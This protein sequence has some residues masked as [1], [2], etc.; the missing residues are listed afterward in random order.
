M[1]IVRK[2]PELPWTR[3]WRNL[4]AAGLPDTIKSTSY[5]ATHDIIPTNER[6]A[7]IHPVPN[8]TCSLC[9]ATDTLQRRITECGEGPV[10]WN[11]TRARTAALLRM[12]P[13]YILEEWTLRPIF[14]YWPT[15]K[16][17]AIVWITAHQVAYRL[18]TQRR[19]S[20]TD[21]TEFL[22]SALWKE[23]HRTPRHP[24]VGRYLDVP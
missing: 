13:K 22:K 9:G 7:A 4:N 15:Q 8:M 6:L 19:P 1:R 23:Y 2:Y 20:L 14:Q 18:Q 16:Q 24:T 17:V 11:W 5:A 3:V 12:H 21:Y 10:M